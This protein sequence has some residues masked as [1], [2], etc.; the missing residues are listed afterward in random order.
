MSSSNDVPQPK[1]I[2]SPFYFDA[3]KLD[4]AIGNYKEVLMELGENEED[5]HQVVRLLGCL[6]YFHLTQPAR[7]RLH[8]PGRGDEYGGGHPALP[9]RIRLSDEARQRRGKRS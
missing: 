2:R 9:P 6:L 5:M 3:G 1:K 4:A 8:L 7:R